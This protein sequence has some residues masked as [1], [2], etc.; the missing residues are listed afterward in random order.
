M[1]EHVKQIYFYMLC[2]YWVGGCGYV[3]LFF[4][5]NPLIYMHN[6]FQFQHQFFEASSI[7]PTGKDGYREGHMSFLGASSTATFYLSLYEN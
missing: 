5:E 1:Q 3:L 7:N 4:Y 2:V 6:T